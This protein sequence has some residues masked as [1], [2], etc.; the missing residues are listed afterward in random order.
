MFVV[1][2]NVAQLIGFLI[3]SFRKCLFAA[4]AALPAFLTVCWG[5]LCKCGC[6]RD[7]DVEA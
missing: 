7:E 1:S 4:F 3:F 2:K 5:R 6:C